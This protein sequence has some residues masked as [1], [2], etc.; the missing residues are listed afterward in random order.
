MRTFHG[1]LPG[2]A[3]TPQQVEERLRPHAFGQHQGLPGIR[4]A[5]GLQHLPPK[6]CHPHPCWEQ[7]PLADG[8]PLPVRGQ[9]T[10]RHQTVYVGM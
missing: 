8:L 2:M 10:A 7:K 9:P 6:H 1:V 4:L 5:D 3:E